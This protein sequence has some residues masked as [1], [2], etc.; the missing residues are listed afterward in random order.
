M[1]NACVNFFVHVQITLDRLCNNLSVL[2]DKL[3]HRA[4]AYESVISQAALC[5]HDYMRRK[6]CRVK[7]KANQLSRQLL[8]VS[9][10]SGTPTLL[11][12]DGK[13]YVAPT[14]CTVALVDLIDCRRRHKMIVMPLLLKI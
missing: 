3:L 13:Y 11:G 8:I 10:K 9:S 5:L 12:Y 7:I 4:P 6:S 1:I 14:G 2:L